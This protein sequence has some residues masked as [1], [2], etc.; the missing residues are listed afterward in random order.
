MWYGVVKV[1][2][3]VK[4][5]TLVWTGFTEGIRM[6]R[7]YLETMSQIQILPPQALFVAQ[8]AV[9][10]TEVVLFPCPQPKVT[11]DADHLHHDLTEE[12]LQHCYKSKMK[13]AYS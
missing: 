8:F 12:S 10:K 2:P 3:Q 1:F 11:K 4:L 13:K 6:A 5:Y 9:S 7:Y